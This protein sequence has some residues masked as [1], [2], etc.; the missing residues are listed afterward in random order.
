MWATTFAAKNKPQFPTQDRVSFQIHM[1]LYKNE[2]IEGLFPWEWLITVLS[3]DWKLITKK[4]FNIQET[5]LNVCS[6]LCIM[7]HTRVEWKCMHLLIQLEYKLHTKNICQ[8]E[9]LV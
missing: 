1:E 6:V 7:C 4:M 9:L 8:N 5:N 2:S 3:N